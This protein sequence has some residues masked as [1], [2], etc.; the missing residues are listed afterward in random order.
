MSR[1]HFRDQEGRPGSAF[2]VDSAD[3][4]TL[5]V[6][7]GTSGRCWIIDI[8]RTDATCRTCDDNYEHDKWVERTLKEVGLLPRAEKRRLIDNGRLSN[9]GRRE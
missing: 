2:N 7:D 8:N 1:L 9:V 4:L 6:I 5:A 3:A